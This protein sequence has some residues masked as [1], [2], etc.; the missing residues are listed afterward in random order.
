MRS[1]LGISVTLIHVPSGPRRWLLYTDALC[2]SRC[3]TLKNP[4]CSMAMRAVYRSKF[5]PFSG[6]GDVS[7]WLKNFSSGTKNPQTNKQ[8]NENHFFGIFLLDLQMYIKLINFSVQLI[9]IENL[10]VVEIWKKSFGEVEKSVA[11]F[12]CQIF[13]RLLKWW[14]QKRRRWSFPPVTQGRQCRM[15]I[16]ER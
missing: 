6:Y 7:I 5:P 2:H 3:G 14:R 12:L 11:K 4:N 10:F 1:A 13:Y 8:S 9:F 15:M 16:D